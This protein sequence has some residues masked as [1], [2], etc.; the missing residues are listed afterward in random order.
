M[1]RHRTPS[2][3]GPGAGSS[4]ESTHEARSRV[5]INQV[6]PALHDPIDE[7]AISLD[8]GE[9]ATLLLK[10]SVSTAPGASKE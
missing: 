8:A 1:D 6:P 2:T 10:V 4:R 3:V 9:T 7:D 5:R